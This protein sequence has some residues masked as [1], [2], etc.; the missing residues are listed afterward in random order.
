[1]QAI[2]ERYLISPFLVFFLVHSMQVGV[3][4]LGFQRIIA[5]SA[6]Y[7]SWIG[8]IVAGIVV[9]IILWM[10]YKILEKSDGDIFK[11]HRD[12]F[13]KWLGSIL[14]LAVIFYFLFMCVIV[15][16][17]YIE[18]L[19]VW[20][21]P[22]FNTWVFS[23][24]ILILC[25]Y[26]ITGG[27]RTVTGISFFSVV[28]PFYLIFSVVFPLQFSEFR[29]LLP[30]F[31]HSV[32]Q[33][34]QATKDMTLS[35]IGFEILF[36]FYPFIKE[37]NKSKKWAHFGNLYT[38]I[39][40]LIF[41]LTALVYYSESQLEKQI[42]ATLSMWK[43][44]EMPFV[45]RFEYIGIASWLL[46]ILP[47]LALTLWASSRGMKRIFS[48]KQKSVLLVFLVVVLL[49]NVYFDTRQSINTMN[50]SMAQMGFYFVYVYIPLLFIITTILHKVRK[51]V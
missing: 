16:R 7:D 39:F 38:T 44:V 48:L 23:I 12:T 49:A 17:T 32:P 21:F 11:V 27:F 3:G 40:Y 35:I 6:G 43:I 19:Q 25:Y 10:M 31:N 22:E 50:E 29:S 4:V 28:L 36:V 42:W 37:P 8:I 18:V 30:I 5:K 9:H 15:L 46:V 2:N 24:F 51:K 1:M 20:L 33:L 41:G 34:L 14:S 47:N 45:E 26:I 13:G